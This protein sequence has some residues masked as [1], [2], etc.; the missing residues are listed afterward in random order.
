MVMAAGAEL[1][2]VVAVVKEVGSRLVGRMLVIH[3]LDLVG[4]YSPGWS[5]AVVAADRGYFLEG[6]RRVDN[7]VMA[8]LWNLDRV[9]VKSMF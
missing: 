8:T 2:A 7:S 1:E 4:I 5:L 6:D 9:I 3:S